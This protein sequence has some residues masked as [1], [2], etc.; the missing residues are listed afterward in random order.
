MAINLSNDVAFELM[1]ESIQIDTLGANYYAIQNTLVQGQKQRVLTAEVENDPARK[2]A[3]C[4]VQTTKGV[5]F[6]DRFIEPD[7]C[8]FRHSYCQQ[9]WNDV[10]LQMQ[11][12]YG[13]NVNDLSGTQIINFILT[14]TQRAWAKQYAKVAWFGNKNNTDVTT[15][16]T[17]GFW[18][19]IKQLVTSGQTPI[20]SNYSNVLLNGD[21]VIDLLDKVIDENAS[22][23]LQDT[24]PAEKVVFIGQNVH[25]ALKRYIKTGAFGSG[26]YRMEVTANGSVP[27]YDGIEL[28]PMFQFSSYAKTAFN[29]ENP[30]LVCYTTRKNLVLGGARNSGNTLIGHYSPDDL[31][32]YITMIT[33]LAQQVKEPKMLSV[34]Y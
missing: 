5:S 18:E 28:V 1:G 27:T 3:G 20:T 32:Y 29:Q 12:F 21:D 34:A 24:D 8:G 15:N 13:A 22:D 23:E 17:D 14:L 4:D 11:N 7:T 16:F 2:F 33:M 25:N 19:Y 10:L 6:S 31:K 9:E 30:N 26:S